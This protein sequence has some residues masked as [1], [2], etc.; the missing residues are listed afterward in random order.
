MLLA[1][2]YGYLAGRER[3]YVGAENWRAVA[4]VFGAQRTR[5]GGRIPGASL[6][7]WRAW[8]SLFGCGRGTG[9]RRRFHRRP[10]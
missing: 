2:D 6:T 3:V 5:L 9:R 4:A 7:G 1:V 10:R 8:R